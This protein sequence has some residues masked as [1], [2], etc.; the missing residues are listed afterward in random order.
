MTGGIELGGARQAVAVRVRPTHR[1]Q[2]EVSPTEVRRRQRLFPVGAAA[3]YLGVS[4]ATVER[5]VYRGELPI[6]K[7][8]AGKCGGGR[9]S[10]R[11]VV[12]SLARSQEGTAF[13][14]AGQQQAVR[15][16]VDRGARQGLLVEMVGACSIARL[17][18]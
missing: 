8:A 14:R 3:A 5:L 17:Q 9:R 4:R 6:V 1:I 11:R 12:C 7:V 18:R 15:S 2:S 16:G 13:S 10:L